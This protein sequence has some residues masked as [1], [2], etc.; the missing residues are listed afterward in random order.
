MPLGFGEKGLVVGRDRGDDASCLLQ[1]QPPFSKKDCELGDPGQQRF[2]AS[3]A[4]T[5]QGVWSIDLQSP[6]TKDKTRLSKPIR[7]DQY[8][9]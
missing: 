2:L 3:S 6:P 9:I 7:K 5:L 4:A 8:A 1:A